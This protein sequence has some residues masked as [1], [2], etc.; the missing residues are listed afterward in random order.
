MTNKTELGVEDYVGQKKQVQKEEKT[1]MG[2]KVY[3]H[4]VTNSKNQM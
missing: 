3:W 2:L 1:S 4:F